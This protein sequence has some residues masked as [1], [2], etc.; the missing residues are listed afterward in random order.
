MGSFRRPASLDG[1][2]GFI[3]DLFAA[4]QFFSETHYLESPTSTKHCE[5]SNL[6]VLCARQAMTLSRS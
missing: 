3:I 5:Q 2:I 1:F 4:Q 6:H